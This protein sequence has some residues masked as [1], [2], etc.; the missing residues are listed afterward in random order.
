MKAKRN[1]KERFDELIALIEKYNYHYYTLD[2]PLVDDASY[3]ELVREL[4]TIEES[5]PE[6]RGLTPLHRKWATP[7][8]AL[9]PRSGTIRRCRAWGMCFSAEELADFDARIK[10][11]AGRESEIIYSVELKFDGLA[12]ELLY[13]SGRFVQGSTRGNGEVGEDVTA[14]IST[15]K[16]VPDAINSVLSPEYLTVRGEVYMRHEEFERLNRQREE[17]GEQPFANPRNAAAAL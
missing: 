4:V 12:V 1:I 17:R 3:D 13:R 9:S 2:T 16:A 5:H 15:I 11:A 10:K 7:Y 6:L 8:R 14:N